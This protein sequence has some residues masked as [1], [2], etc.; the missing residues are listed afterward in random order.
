[1]RMFELQSANPALVL[2]IS[3]CLASPSNEVLRRFSVTIVSDHLT[4]FPGIYPYNSHIRQ[5]IT[6]PFYITAKRN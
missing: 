5:D 3:C 4:L 6:E 1:M 2:L